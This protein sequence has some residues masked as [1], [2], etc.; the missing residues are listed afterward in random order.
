MCGTIV[1]SWFYMLLV[2][3]T[4]SLTLYVILELEYPRLGAIRIDAADQT[5]VELRNTM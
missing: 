5:L 1:R 2:A 3:T 4:M